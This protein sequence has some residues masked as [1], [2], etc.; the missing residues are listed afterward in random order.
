MKTQCSAKSLGFHPLGRRK[1]V[2][3][4][5]GGTI[6]SEAGGL[7]LRSVEKA[8][9]IIKQFA[10]CF[11]DHRDPDCIEHRVEELAGQRVYGRSAKWRLSCNSRLELGLRKVRLPN[12]HRIS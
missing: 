10:S 5:D 12:S 6:T 11:V 7:L 9:G 8:T 3:R 2:A 4:F 1:I